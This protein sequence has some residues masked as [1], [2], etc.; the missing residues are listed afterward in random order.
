MEDISN[1][2]PNAKPSILNRFKFFHAIPADI[3]LLHTITALRYVPRQGL[4]QRG[5]DP[6]HIIDV[7]EHSL[8]VKSVLRKAYNAGVLD[9]FLRSEQEPQETIKKAFRK[10]ERHDLQ[11]TLTTDF[12]PS[13]MSIISKQEKNHLEELAARII[14]EV[15]PER[16]REFMEYEAKQGKDDILVKMADYIAWAGEALNCYATVE[17]FDGKPP[18]TLEQ[19]MA[20]TREKMQQYPE[21]YEAFGNAYLAAMEF[22][23][24]NLM[25]SIT[26]ARTKD[27]K[28]TA[29]VII[30]IATPTG[31]RAA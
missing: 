22:M 13:D 8:G 23:M 17:Y 29:N 11:E 14:Y 19:I 3:R 7:R 16:Y 15:H 4:I 18:E 28:K 6:A 12:T 25:P 30:E 9:D 24:E 1:R 20:D 31:P 26:Y 21:A 5:Y 10:A 2:F 27:A